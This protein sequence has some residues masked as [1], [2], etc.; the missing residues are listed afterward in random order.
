MLK[1]SQ[2]TIEN[3]RGGFQMQIFASSRTLLSLEELET[4]SNQIRLFSLFLRSMRDN[5]KLDSFWEQ[6]IPKSLV[7]EN[8]HR[9]FDFTFST[10][11]NA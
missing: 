10:V 1:T 2:T 7:V 6:V 8:V 5:L 3:D 11:I 4:C 9:Y